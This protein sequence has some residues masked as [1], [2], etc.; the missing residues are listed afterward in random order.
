MEERLMKNI[1]VL[2]NI[3]SNIVEEA[4]VVLKPNLKI[5]QTEYIAKSKDNKQSKDKDYIVRE[6]ESVIS[7]YISVLDKQDNKKDIGTKKLSEKYKRLKMVTFLLGGIV[8][9][10]IIIRILT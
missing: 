1:I 10:N 9:F 6:A 2:K 8:L 7:N 4:I 3:P 5:K